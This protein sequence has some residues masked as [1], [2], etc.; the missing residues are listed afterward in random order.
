ASESTRLVYRR[1]TVASVTGSAPGAGWTL[2]RGRRLPTIGYGS[3]ETEEEPNAVDECLILGVAGF[4]WCM[5]FWFL[6]TLSILLFYVRQLDG[7]E[8]GKSTY[9]IWM[10]KYQGS[11]WMTFTPFWIGD[12]VAFAFLGRLIKKV[13]EVRLSG[14]SRRGPRRFES[15]EA[16]LGGDTI[17]VNIDYFPLLQRVVITWAVSL[18]ILIIVIIEQVLV[19]LKWDGGGRAPGALA[20]ATPMLVLE[21]LCLLRV[22]LLRCHGWIS[23]AT[24]ILTILLTLSVALRAEPATDFLRDRPWAQCLTP[25]WALDVLYLGVVVYLLAN[26]CVRRLILSRVQAACLALYSISLLCSIAAQLLLIEDGRRGIKLSMPPSRIFQLDLHI[27]LEMF[28]LGAFILAIYLS[29][30]HSVSQLR[31]S[32]GYE[33]PLPLSKTEEGWEWSGTGTARWG[34]LGDIV[35]R[36]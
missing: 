4:G 24:W 34:L 36:A 3:Y 20:V 33:D 16:C 6:G 9:G 15:R 8:H 23:G 12:I 35:M 1:A 30:D 14:T 17:I 25:L 19:C 5:L 32:H 26:V 13:V 7:G 11:P 31:A 2:P 29:I 22:V 28:S 18:L 10:F 21:I 27:L